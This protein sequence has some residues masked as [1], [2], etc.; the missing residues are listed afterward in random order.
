MGLILMAGRR[1]VQQ[2]FGESCRAAHLRYARCDARVQPMI[3]FTRG[4]VP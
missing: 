3:D 1:D 4:M 2:Q